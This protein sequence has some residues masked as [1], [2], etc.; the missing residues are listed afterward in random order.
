[1]APNILSSSFEDVSLKEADLIEFTLLISFKGQE[2]KVRCVEDRVMVT[3]HPQDKVVGYVRRGSTR[4]GAIWLLDE[5]VADY[6][7]SDDGKYMVTEI[8]DSFRVPEKQT[9]ADPVVYLLNSVWSAS[10]KNLTPV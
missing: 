10:A 8:R 5:C 1:M 9:E 3:V 4:G 2:F 7:V 6:I